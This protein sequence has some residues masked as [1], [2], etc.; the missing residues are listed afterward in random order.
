[1]GGKAP[2]YLN[3]KG[4]RCEEAS[5]W[6]QPEWAREMTAARPATSCKYFYMVLSSPFLH[7]GEGSLH[8][9]WGL[10]HPP[11][12][13]HFCSQTAG[14]TSPYWKA[15]RVSI[16]VFWFLGLFSGSITVYVFMFM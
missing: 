11:E 8:I 2:E 13:K 9:S 12:H 5:E 15:Q 1:M 4:P 16:F 3:W 6:E 10:D 14:A 7:L